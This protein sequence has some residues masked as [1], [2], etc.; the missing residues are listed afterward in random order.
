MQMTNEDIIALFM[1]V[2]AVFVLIAA[3]LLIWTLI[4]CARINDVLKTLSPS[5][6]RDGQGRPLRERL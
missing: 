4:L 2:A 3:A 5:R 1:M 6:S